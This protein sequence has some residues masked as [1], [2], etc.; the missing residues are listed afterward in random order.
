MKRKAVREDGAIWCSRCERFCPPAEFG[1]SRSRWNGLSPYCSSCMR[2][3]HT[4]WRR[5][6]EIKPYDERRTPPG[7]CGRCKRIRP[8]EDFYRRDGISRGH[9][10][11][12]KDCWGKFTKAEWKRTK[13]NP[14]LHARYKKIAR[15]QAV[16]RRKA[17]KTDPEKRRVYAAH[18]LIRWMLFGG[19]ME[20]KPCQI[21]GVTKV[22]A[23]H[24]DYSRPLEVIW[25]CRDHHNAIRLSP[26]PTPRSSAASASP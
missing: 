23:H 8:V 15:E 3:K 7:Y 5:G 13:S 16:R 10:H 22:E 21:C 26:A 24:A 1:K 17:A 20:R 14:K 4:E 19:W 6:V 18:Q 25:L 12:C 9:S 2:S 11:I